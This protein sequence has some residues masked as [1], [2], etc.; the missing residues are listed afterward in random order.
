[1]RIIKMEQ[2]GFVLPIILVFVLIFSML[3]LHALSNTTMMF[4]LNQQL[5][6]KEKALLTAKY[7]LRNIETQINTVVSQCSIPVISPNELARKTNSWW[8]IN[9]CSGNLS[10]NQYYYAVESLGK[11][12]CG[13]VIQHASQILAVAEYYRVSILFLPSNLANGK[14]ILQSI[15]AMPNDKVLA[16]NDQ[17][18]VVVSG[19]QMWRELVARSG[20]EN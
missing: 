12:N 4:R 18:H 16:C 5:W 10:G 19:Q 17:L 15:V 6:L 20:N 7:I 13:V 14:I 3:S 11:D 2:Y 9:F 8:Q 1:M